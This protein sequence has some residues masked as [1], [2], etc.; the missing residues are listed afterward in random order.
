[1]KIALTGMVL[2]LFGFAAQADLKT[3]S[4]V[5]PSLYVGTWYQI[6][7]NPHPFEAGCVCSRQILTPINSLEI[8]VYNSCNLNSVAGELSEIRGVAFNDDPA[9]NSRFTVDFNLPFKGQ[10]WIVGIDPQYRWAVVSEPSKRTLYILSKTPELSAELY[11]AAVAEAA[12]QLDVSQLFKTEQAGC[13]YPAASK[14]SPKTVAAP[15]DPNHPGSK[16]YNHESIRR[17]L[18]CSGR[19]VTVFLPSRS[20]SDK[21][22]AVVYG[23]GQAL[24]LE[25][26][27]GTL[28][29]LAKKGV[30]AIFP[31]YDNGFFDQDWPRMARDYVNL[32]HCAIQQTGEAVDRARIIFSGHSKGAYV[33]SI[34]A[35]LAEKD[36]LP[37]RPKGVALFATAGFDSAS[38]AHVATTTAVTVVYSDQDTV[39]GRNFSDSYYSAVPSVKKQFIFLKSY[40]G[41]PAA[42][43]QWPLTKGG[44]FG[45][46]GEGPLHYYGG[47]KWLVAHALDMNEYLYGAEATDKGVPGLRDDMNKNF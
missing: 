45:G 8:G 6:A 40:P 13:Q 14:T 16:I 32:T 19:D 38:A 26:Y 7:R 18:T 11:E 44:F 10:Y 25:N 33:A 15:T 35:G 41:G 2:A 20:G 1:M 21:F 29:H 39:V 23:H 34:A 31:T 28:E 17:D 30:A 22:P 43:H 24:G 36:S 27:K 4:Y 5:D 12:Q 46:G 37:V 3:V 9:S 47:W 42:D